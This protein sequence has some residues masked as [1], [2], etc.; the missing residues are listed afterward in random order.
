[1]K[2]LKFGGTSMG[3]ADAMRQVKQI[4]ESQK[5]SVVVV[6]SAVSG[7]TDQLIKASEE[8]Q[9][10]IGYQNTLDDIVSLHNT[11]IQ[12]LFSK[13]ALEQVIKQQEPVWTELHQI[14]KG[15]S[16]TKE[17]STKSYDSIVGSGERLSSIILSHLLTDAKLYDSR[18]FIKTELNGHGHHVLN[19]PTMQAI[20]ELKFSIGSR[21]VFPGFIA[22]NAAG[23][24]TTLGRG[25]SDYSAALLAAGLDAEILEIWTDVD[26][27]MSADPRVIRRA[28]CIEHLSFSEAMELSHF[29]A[30]VIYPPTIIPVLQ[31]QI[32][33]KVKNT[34]NPEAPGTLIDH[35]KDEKQDVKGLSSIREVALLTLQGN[36]MIG[37][38]GISMRMFGALAKEAI[39]IV[40][41]SQASSES[42]ISVVLAA[43]DAER[44][45]LA[46][47][48][49]FDKE[50]SRQE[51]NGITL[52]KDMAVVAIVGEGMKH[53][54]GVSGQLF[55]A[56]GR[57]GINIYA[58]AQGAS[59]LNISFVIHENDLRKTL[60]VVHETFFL[61]KFQAIHLYQVGVGTVG[62]N[63]LQKIERQSERLLKT[64][65]LSIRLAGLA[66]SCQMIFNDRGLELDSAVEVLQHASKGD[67]DQFVEQIIAN[68]HSNS[69]FVDCTASAV[70]AEKYQRLLENNISVVTANKIAGSSAYDRYET[71]KKTARQ[72]G[73]KYLFETNVGAGLPIINTIS[74][75]VNSGDRILQLEAV[76]SGTLNYIVNNVSAEKP[77]SA[78]VIE[79]KEK[80][81]SEPDP[82]IDLK[83]TDVLRKLL[84]LA[85]ESDYALEQEHVEISPFLPDEFFKDES[86][87]DFIERVKS[88]DATFE[89]WR[90]EAES[91]GKVLRYAASLKAGHAKVG[92]IE[93]DAEHPFYNLADSNNKVILRSDYYYDHPMEIKGYGAGADVTAAGVFADIIKV[94][95]L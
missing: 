53:T 19:N 94:V 52:E 74:N 18:Q 69:V 12:Q 95:N 65:H 16:L 71:L 66:N 77:L 36:G 11:I 60:N 6:V 15:V 10:G 41:I 3:S 80:G 30:K 14:L 7:V 8:A 91:K 47:L 56:V 84:I 54:S 75:M 21:S 39:N 32:P 87:A 33:V 34:F 35:Q 17:L 2:V 70:V 27:F 9:D 61:S 1:M 50:I 4:V 79:A 67:I 31:K 46:L 20:G 76:L 45:R 86:V 42:S 37:I 93:V 92:F 68:N 5:V 89:A 43:K 90:N 38:S 59:E 24:N 48:R 29:G 62:K 81:Y 72:K 85:R 82:R 78:V 83:G 57:N 44:A 88:Y 40:L 22:S 51:I 64:E 23:D 49:E 63:L 73:V 26:G 28:Y 25:G 13:E 55:N 58:I